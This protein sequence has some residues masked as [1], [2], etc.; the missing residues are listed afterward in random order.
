MQVV[1][2]VVTARD[3]AATLAET[4]EGVAKAFPNSPVWVADDGSK[5][6]TA[7]IAAAAGARVLIAPRRVG[8]GGAATLAADTAL[9][10]VAER[11]RTG[12]VVLCDGDLGLSASALARL[13]V[14]ISAGEA[15]IAVGAFS[16]PAGGGFGIVL[17]YARY[18]VRRRCGVLLEAPLSGQRAIRVEAL[19]DLLP[20]AAGFGM[21]LGIALDAAGAGRRIVE[22]ELDLTHRVTGRTPRGFLHRGR[23]LIDL[24][25][26]ARR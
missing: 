24:V 8:K 17:G 13:L 14:P 10:A 5:D 21:E 20:F 25:R 16:N 1:G 3:E 4:L 23:Q 15:D 7:Q 2:V 6:A 9:E 19:R 26:V 18:V 11:D 12:A 22:V